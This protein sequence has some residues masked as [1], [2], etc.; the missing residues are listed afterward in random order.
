MALPISV[1]MVEDA[2]AVASS[3]SLLLGLRGHAVQT[4]V[5]AEQFLPAMQHLPPA[6]CCSIGFFPASRDLPRWR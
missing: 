3:L 1:Y 4:F 5:T 6:A 2:A